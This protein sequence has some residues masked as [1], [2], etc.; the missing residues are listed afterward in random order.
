MRTSSDQTHSARVG[1]LALYEASASVDVDTELC[2]SRI[3]REEFSGWTVSSVAHRLSTIRE[4]DLIIV[5]NSGLVI[6]FWKQAEWKVLVAVF[7]GTW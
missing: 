2:I 6:E 1:G 5:T 4:S 3:V 7:G